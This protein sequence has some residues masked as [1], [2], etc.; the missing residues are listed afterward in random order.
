MAAENNKALK[1]LRTLRIAAMANKQT[2]VCCLAW[3]R[4]H[5]D[6]LSVGGLQ[7]RTLRKSLFWNFLLFIGSLL[8][9]LV[10]LVMLIVG[11]CWCISGQA[12][13]WYLSIFQ[14][15]IV[16]C[17]LKKQSSRKKQPDELKYIH[18]N[19]QQAPCSFYVSLVSLV[20]HHSTTAEN[21]PA[22]LLHRKH[23]KFCASP[24][25]PGDLSQNSYGKAHDLRL[26]IQWN[27]QTHSI[28]DGVSVCGSQCSKFLSIKRTITISMASII[29]LSCVSTI[30]QVFLPIYYK[31]NR[32]GVSIWQGQFFWF[33]IRVTPI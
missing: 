1:V 4:T 26:V 14:S 30:Y 6:F 18:I 21:E 13:Q 27:H 32:T 29:Q 20:S 24:Y 12:N 3:I 25:S 10:M 16:K 7:R 5:K 11:E 15:C 8:V 22:N 17:H 28:A 9:M 19:K 23:S 2:V 31:L 33:E